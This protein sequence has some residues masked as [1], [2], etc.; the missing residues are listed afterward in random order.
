MEN[1]Y[2][3]DFLEKIYKMDTKDLIMI[4]VDKM[5]KEEQNKK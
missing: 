3:K 4:L 1:K 5:K 2:D